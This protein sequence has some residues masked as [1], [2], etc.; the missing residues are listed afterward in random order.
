MSCYYNNEVCEGDEWICDRCGEDYCEAHGHWTSRGENVECVACEAMRREEE[1]R[2]AK[3]HAEVQRKADDEALNDFVGG[4][5]F[6][7]DSCDV[8]AA[9][10]AG[11]TL[12]AAEY[13][14]GAGEDKS[15]K[16]RRIIKRL[17]PDGML[18][19]AEEE[20]FAKIPYVRCD[21]CGSTWYKPVRGDECCK[22]PLVAA[23]G[24]FRSARSVTRY[25]VEPHA[26]CRAA[27]RCIEPVS[28]KERCR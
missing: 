4:H 12:Y 20:A 22:R 24:P 17:A 16:I 18:F 1:K 9:L 21:Y 5:A 14:C 2:E 13:L 23:P 15:G 6:C 28:K 8:K 27:G 10:G 3:E 25:A 26:R 7:E 19:A 11:L